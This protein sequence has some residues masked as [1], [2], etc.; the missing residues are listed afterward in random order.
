MSAAKPSQYRPILHCRSGQDLNS[1]NQSS[2]PLQLLHL[3]DLHLFADA[4]GRLLGVTT[5]ASF[6]AVLELALASVPEATALI[7]TGDL[8]HDESTAGYRYLRRVL[9]MTNLPYFCIPGNHDRQNPMVD[10]LGSAALGPIALRRL[11]AWNLVFLDSTI[12]GSEGGRVSREQLEQLG[13]LLDD[14]DA[15]TLLFIHH[16]PSPV[17]SAWVDTMGV[18]NGA[19]LLELCDTYPQVKGIAFGHVHQ[20]FSRLH[21]NMLMMGTPSTCIQFLP[22]NDV[23]ALDE[24]PPGFRVL[25]LHPH[26]EF[27]SE[28]A[29][30]DRA[31]ESPLLQA[32]GY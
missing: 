18:A 19:E 28:V 24:A 7:L 21:G 13:G 2:D 6:E 14:D 25:T 11:G 16:H 5:R 1:S 20:S 22:G 31:L 30:L 29:R 17:G 9:D 26:G 4:S 8:V 3:T 27:T 23:F 12:V 15:P 32:E 10:C